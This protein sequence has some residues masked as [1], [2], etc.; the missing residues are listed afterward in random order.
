V[1]FCWDPNKAEENW[2]KHRVRFEE[3]QTLFFDRHFVSVEDA[4]HSDSE[5]RYFA[6]GETTEG[7]LIAV[8]YTIRRDESWIIS[9][10]LPTRAEHRRYMRGD[11]IRD[12]G[13]EKEEEDITAHLDWKNA[14]RGRHYV[15][16]RGPITVQIESKLAEF[17]RDQYAVNEALR[18]LIREGRVGMWSSK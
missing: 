2:R 15:K 11:R 4:A 12:H 1:K 13:M 5:D 7:R 14:V 17:F 18:L 16:P 8:T 10:R 3:A 9:A 6:L